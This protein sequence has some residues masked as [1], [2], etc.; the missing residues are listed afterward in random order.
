MNDVNIVESLEIRF[1]STDND[2][3]KISI[4]ELLSYYYILINK[5]HNKGYIIPSIMSDKKK[6]IKPK[7]S[8]FSNRIE[9]GKIFYHNGI[10]SKIC[11]ECNDVNTIYKFYKS[12]HSTTGRMHICNKCFRKKYQ[13]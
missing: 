7:L 9:F 6:I 10:A 1:Q 12:K 3:E 2:N 4:M 11:K 13:L 5:T 8:S